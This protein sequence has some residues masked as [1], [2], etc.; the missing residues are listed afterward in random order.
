MMAESSH[1]SIEEASSTR[2]DVRSRIVAC[3]IDL[4]TQGGRDALTT[5]A[6]AAAAQVQA[7]TL[8]RLFGDKQGL[9]D[10]VAEYGF[11]TYLNEKNVREPSSD[12]VEDL[13]KGWDLHVEFGLAHPA[14]YSLMYGDPRP[15]L[16]S[17]AAETARKTLEKHIQRIAIA[18]RLRVDEAR[19]A[20]LVHAAGCGTVFT[21][22]AMPADGRD[23]G[24]SRDARESVI[25]AITT[26]AAAV[27]A[28]GLEGAAIALRAALPDA[29][30][31]T[32]GERHLLEE[33]LER[34]ATS[35]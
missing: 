16:R 26:D 6:V 34:I 32:Q 15:G 12:P 33:W 21:L 27:K 18:G 28:P 10:A 20:D 23:G 7:P 25:T 24:L 14:L 1:S 9:L 31:L 30:T 13:R 17:P 4:L 29:K 22:L 35:R 3:A 2:D 8:Y 5:R 19:A 11:V